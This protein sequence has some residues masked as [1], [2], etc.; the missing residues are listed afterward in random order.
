MAYT[1]GTL[2]C[3][4]PGLR[5]AMQCARA[6]AGQGTGAVKEAVGEVVA[7]SAISTV[8]RGGPRR[9]AFIDGDCNSLAA[10][11]ADVATGQDVGHACFQLSVGDDVA[12]GIQLDH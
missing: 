12:R 3:T 5:R 6:E 2:H 4:R 11:P 8:V 7:R 9:G 10:P 1:D